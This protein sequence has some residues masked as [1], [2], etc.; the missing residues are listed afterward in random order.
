ML[1]SS[2]RLVDARVAWVRMIVPG[3]MPQCGYFAQPDR[4]ARLALDGPLLPAEWTTEINYL[5]NSDGSLSLSLSEGPDV[6][7]PVHPGLNRVYV[8]LPGAGDAITARADTAALAVCIAAG[9]VGY[10]TPR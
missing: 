7:V 4:P 9:P 5:A 10:V 3:P 6:K 8:R 1:D 2:G